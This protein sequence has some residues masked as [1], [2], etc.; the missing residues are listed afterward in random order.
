MVE[1]VNY[2]PWP[3][4]QVP[5]ELQRPELRQLKE[6]GYV[7]DDARD[8]VEIFEKRV[9]EFAGSKHAISVDSC[10]HGIEL[11]LR[12]LISIGELSQRS[13]LFV[14]ANTYISIFWTLKQMGFSVRFE[15]KEWEGVYQ[16]EGTRVYDSAVRWKRN[17]Y[18]K[19]SLQCVSFQIKKIIPIGRGGVILTDDD[20]AAKWLKLSSYDGRD[21]TT[22]YDQ[23]GHVKMNGYHYYLPPEECARGI[24]LMDKIK[25]QGDSA[26]YKNYPDINQIIKV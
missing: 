20:N 4:G 21:L 25:F 7:F 16:I 6:A 5:E 2:N 8:V 18:I 19:D 12:W 1:K 10:T 15:E 26:S 9:S 11:S 14:P 22:P 17:M 23:P 3:N 24:I 13:T